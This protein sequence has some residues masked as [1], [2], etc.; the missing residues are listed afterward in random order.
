MPLSRI[1]TTL[2]SGETSDS[3]LRTLLTP[4]API[5]VTA[6][7]GNS[8]ATVSWT[9]PT[10]V[11]AQAPIT[12]FVV[13]FQP[14]GGSWQPFTDGTSTATTAT[15]TGLTN[16]TAY[17]FRVAA[18]NALGTSAYS[19]AST[20]VT[21]VTGDPLFSSVS[22]LLHM[23]G[24]GS[25]FT[26][27]SQTPKAI[28]AIGNTT[29]STAQSKFGGSSAYFDGNGARLTTSASEAFYFANGDYTVEAWLYIT[30]LNTSGGGNFFSQSA[31]LNNNN[32]RQYAFAVNSTGLKV[33]WTTDGANDT[34]L[35]F[36]ATPPTNEWFHV[37]FARQSGVLRAYINGVQVGSSQSHTATYFN[38][39]ANVCVGSFGG[40]AVDGYAFLDYTGYI[41]DLRITKG[42]AR[43]TAN[44]TPP[45]SAFPTS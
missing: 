31:N 43:Y 45:M 35:T 21:P 26:D 30:S 2:F 32:N 7:A 8:Q 13:Q 11:I 14:S 41:D 4:S 18:T 38:S 19:T 44:F 16:G 10:G 22:L 1:Q 23:D 5:N 40:Y 28:T 24:T 36:S 37:A 29:Q 12:D 42:H 6:S 20:T 15:V 17:Q 27:S 25:T 39:T 33:Y 34:D 9:A 3:V